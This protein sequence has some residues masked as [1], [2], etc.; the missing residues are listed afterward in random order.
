MSTH[1]RTYPADTAL[2]EPGI[3]GAPGTGR[4]SAQSASFID[5]KARESDSA[6]LIEGWYT[7]LPDVDRVVLTAEFGEDMVANGAEAFL[8]GGRLDRRQH[9]LRR[10]LGR[11]S[12]RDRRADRRSA[13]RLAGRPG[14]RVPA[15]QHKRE[16]GPVGLEPTTY[17]LKERPKPAWKACDRPFRAWFVD[18]G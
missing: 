12:G 14:G 8:L 3:E 1:R 10:N 5:A 15:D 4:K 2:G 17:G 11:Q 9:G 18:A 7:S 6:G 13:P 16:V